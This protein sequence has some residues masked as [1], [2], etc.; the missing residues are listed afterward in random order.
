MQLWLNPAEH[1]SM[2]SNS[3]ALTQDRYGHN[4]FYLCLWGV[5][6]IFYKKII[7]ILYNLHSITCKKQDQ[8]FANKRE[9]MVEFKTS[10]W[11][12][13]F[14]FFFSTFKK[15]SQGLPWWRSGWDSVLPMQGAGVQSLISELD[16]ICMPQLRVRMP[17]LRSLCAATKEPVNCN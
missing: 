5:L 10:Y 8:G 2:L 15:K 9:A 3:F 12:A 14:L 17:Q 6:L 11:T 4:R 7:I 16:P 1:A 13:V